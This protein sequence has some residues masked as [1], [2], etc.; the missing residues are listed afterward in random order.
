[1]VRS[2]LARPMPWI[3]RLAL[4]LVLPP[5][6]IL[7]RDAVR[8]ALDDHLVP[9]P[10]DTAERPVG[11]D[12]VERVEGAVHDLA[13]G[14]QIA[15][16]AVTEG[17]QARGHREDH[18]L[19]PEGCP[20]HVRG[21]GG[22][23]DRRQG[24][25]D[26]DPVQPGE[27]AGQ[28][29]PQLGEDHQRG[30]GRRDRLRGEQQDGDD[31]LGDVVGGHLGPV[32]R[33][34]EM[35]EEPA[36]RARHRLC[37]MVV[38]QAGQLPPARVAPHLDQPG[39]EL[40]PEQHP[41]QQEEDDDRWGH[42]VVAEEDREETHL[43][44][45]R[46]P[47]ERVPRLADVDDRQIQRPGNEPQQH[48]APERQLRVQACDQRHRHRAARPGPGRVE[49]V[50]VVPVEHARR[51]TERHALHETGDRQHPALPD[52]RAELHRRAQERD[53]VHDG[54]RP[55]EDQPAQPVLGGDEPLH[56]E[57]SSPFHCDAG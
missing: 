56:V 10:A 3:T 17:H 51:V 29:Q 48:S 23:L 52:Q 32:E 55:L 11:V 22:E 1:M 4:E 6:R 40:H 24:Q 8:R 31:E 15:H 53:E 37:L 43:Q 57:C 12:Q 34:G 50:R 2:E 35:V 14:E 18:D 39:A 54:Q 20:G 16:R 5:L 47:P 45:Q 38:V 7:Q 42:L 26:G 27:V 28:D 13:P 44:Q 33:L 19:E 25:H 36:Q 49:A 21:G 30:G 9:H 46:L 41:A